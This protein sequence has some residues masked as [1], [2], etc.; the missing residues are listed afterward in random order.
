V[1]ITDLPI[2][3]EKIVNALKESG[4]SGG[5]AVAAGKERADAV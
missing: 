4:P 3:G 5:K 2:S 1:R